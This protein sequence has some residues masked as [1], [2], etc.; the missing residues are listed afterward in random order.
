MCPSPE[1]SL[2]PTRATCSKDL[3]QSIQQTP[4]GHACAPS[5]P[6]APCGS[7]PHT[8]TASWFVPV[9]C[10]AAWPAPATLVA[11]LAAASSAKA[12]AATGVTG[13]TLH[14]ATTSAADC[15]NACPP[16]D[17]V[18]CRL[19]LCMPTKRLRPL[20]TALMHAQQGTCRYSYITSQD[21]NVHGANRSHGTV[22]RSA[23][24]VNLH[25]NC[26][27]G[28]ATCIAVQCS[29]HENN[30]PLKGLPRQL[31]VLGSYAGEPRPSMNTNLL[32]FA[33]TL[34]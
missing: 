15:C 28:G 25:C 29:K 21:F 30:L 22:Q 3:P 4:I 6:S 32:N 9:F 14:Q 34:L 7:Q 13:Q 1:W 33:S 12:H 27:R 26:P 16:S 24:P 5:L 11:A 18:R 23:L 17:C 19:L 10:L 2:S 20:Q 31:A 8:S